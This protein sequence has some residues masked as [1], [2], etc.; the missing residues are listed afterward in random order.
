MFLKIDPWDPAPPHPRLRYHQLSEIPP[1]A[2]ALSTLFLKIDP[3]PRARPRRRHSNEGPLA[4]TSATPGRRGSCR[5]PRGSSGPGQGARI[6]RV[7]AMGVR[8]DRRRSRYR[9][10]RRRGGA[11]GRRQ[12][13]VPQPP[14]RCRRRCSGFAACRNAHLLQLLLVASDEGDCAHRSR[15]RRQGR[16]AETSS[17]AHGSRNNGQ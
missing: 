8:G 14:A 6:G 1:R 7:V 3:S 5:R 15:G 17:S 12:G 9:R 13:G 4:L 2:P 10:A 16:A 11:G